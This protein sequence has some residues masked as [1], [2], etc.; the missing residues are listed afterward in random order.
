MRGAKDFEAQ[1]HAIAE[2]VQDVL[3]A[4]L[5]LKEAADAHAYARSQECSAS[6]TKSTAEK[7][8]T[9]AQDKLDQL[10]KQPPTA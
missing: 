10:L 7:K 9:T 5:Q 1:Q 2:Q 3:E 6:N 8:L 4:R